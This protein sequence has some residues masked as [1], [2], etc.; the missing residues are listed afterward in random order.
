MRDPNR[1]PELLNLIGQVWMLAPDL[2]ICQVL[3]HAAYLSGHTLSNDLF[4]V[5]DDKMV[6]GLRLWIEENEK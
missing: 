3:L 5:E 1:I 4:Y 6:E 2:R